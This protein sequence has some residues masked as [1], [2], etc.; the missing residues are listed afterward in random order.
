MLRIS[1]ENSIWFFD[2]DDTLIDTAGVT[3]Q[4]AVGIEEVFSKNFTPEIGQKVK[5]NFLTIFDL[6][7]A[8]Y[9]VKDD[10]WGNV[11]G[12]KKAFNELINRI[13]SCQ[14]KII[15]EY[16][17]AKKWSRE[18]FIYLAAQNIGLTVQPE[19]IHE[20]ADAY[21]I[22]LTEVTQVFESA[23]KLFKLIESHKRPIFLITSSDARLILNKNGQFEYDP[24]YSEKKKRE[25]MEIL[26]EKGLNFNTLTIGDPE[27]KP[28]IEFF[29]KGIRSAE[30]FF[31]ES[32]NNENCII[33]GDS[34]GGDLQ[35]PKEELGFGLCVLFEKPLDSIK[36]I[37]TGLIST[38]NLENI[39]MYLA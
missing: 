33:V 34:Y 35:T 30:Q 36:A 4:S 9:R 28:S 13:E 29:Q 6:M 3:K 19:I 12:G 26:R 15:S 31:N 10:N 11:S 22:K 24:A 23:L 1:W 8:G 7:L 27:D 17:K 32:I 16:G 37:E 18:V 21:W 38:G 25:R 2:I 5:E 20:A 14:E 39:S